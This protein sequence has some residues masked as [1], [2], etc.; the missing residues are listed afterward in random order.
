[1]FITIRYIKK[2]KKMTALK[3]GTCGMANPLAKTSYPS[4]TTCMYTEAVKQ[5]KIIGLY[6]N[7]GRVGAWC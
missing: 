6:L 7:L 4:F 1:M 2:E 3:H 5:V